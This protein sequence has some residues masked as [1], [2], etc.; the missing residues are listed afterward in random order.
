MF[1][2]ASAWPVQPCK[3]VADTTIQCEFDMLTHH[4]NGTQASRT[5]AHNKGTCSFAH[6]A[7]CTKSDL[8]IASLI[9]RHKRKGGGVTGGG[10]NWPGPSWHVV[11][12]CAKHGRHAGRGSI[13]TYQ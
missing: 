5:R 9:I 4:A 8:L 12:G 10:G 1:E 13:S 6:L 3:L 11:G 7:I 2:R